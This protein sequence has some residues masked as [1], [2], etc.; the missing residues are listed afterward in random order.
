MIHRLL[1]TLAMVALITGCPTGGDD[2]TFSGDDDD[3][4]AGTITVRGN[5]HDLGDLDATVSGVTVVVANPAGMLVSG[6]DP[7][8]L[9]VGTVDPDGSFEVTDVDPT[10]ADMGL[11]MIVDDNGEAYL[12]VAT[13][14]HADEY[15]GWTDG[16]V[17][18][19]QVAFAASADFVAALELDLAIAGWHGELFDGGALIGFVQD[20]DMEP[21]GDATVTSTEDYTV[22]YADDDPIGEGAFVD[23]T[24]TPNAATSV[25]SDALWVAPGGGVDNWSAEADGYTYDPI[26]VGSTEEILVVIAFRP[27]E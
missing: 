12:S 24:T 27:T 21:I 6:D 17:V 25:D 7:A 2:D 9:G 19:D 22:Y 13:G 8:A 1:I 16:T 18:E 3:A 15:A 14:I 11:I 23:A 20:G 5:V 26:L 4:D 10:G